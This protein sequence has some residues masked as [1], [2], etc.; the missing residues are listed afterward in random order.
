[1]RE[2]SRAQPKHALGGG[3]SD[4]APLQEVVDGVD[5]AAPPAKKARYSMSLGDDESAAPAAAGSAAPAAGPAAPAAGGT[6][7]TP[8]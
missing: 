2:G 6:P 4:D 1:M 7:A 5:G 8:P 3:A